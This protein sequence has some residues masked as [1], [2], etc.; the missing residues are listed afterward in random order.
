MQN[1]ESESKNMLSVQ[2]V[3]ER[4]GI[5]A[6]LVRSLIDRRKLQAVNFGNGKNA[7]YRIKPEWIEDCVNACEL[8]PIK[9]AQKENKN[10]RPS[11]FTNVRSFS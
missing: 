1:R 4:M 9:K 7:C 3:A 5:S 11:K 6:N 10:L 2:Q 8:P